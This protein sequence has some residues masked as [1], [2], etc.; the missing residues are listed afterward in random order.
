MK[1]KYDYKYFKDLDENSP[2][3]VDFEELSVS[4]RARLESLQGEFRAKMSVLKEIRDLN[5]SD[6][7]DEKRTTRDSLL[8][9]VKRVV[10]EIENFPQRK[11]DD[12][13]D[14]DLDDDGFSNQ[15]QRKGAYEVRSS[16]D[17][18]DFRALFG[19]EPLNH[20][21]WTDENIDFFS[22]VFAGR[23]HPDLQV[24]AM[25]IGVDSDGGFLV[26]VEYAEEIHNVSLENEIVMPGAMVIPM[27]VNEKKLPGLNIGDHSANLFGGFEASYK[28][29]AGT[30]G[31]KNPKTRQVKLS[32]KK[33]TGFLRL[34]RELFDDIP[35]GGHQVADICG[36]GLAWYRD[37]AFLKG[38]GAGEPQG[39][40]N[41]ACLVTVDKETGQAAATITYPNLCDMMSRMFAGSFKNSV[42]VAHQTCIPQLLQLTIAVGTGGA[43][44]PV[45]TKSK[46]GQFEILTRPVIF[47]EKT[48]TLGTK[49]DIMLCDFGQYV[50][51]LR[52][53]MRLDFSP[54]VYFATD[55]VAARLIERHDG[56]P[57]WSEALTLEDGSTTV[58]PFVTLAERT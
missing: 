37:K 33:L 55:E 43:F 12:D 48:E 52:E 35:G 40:L 1:K 23:F 14:I 30:L 17:K 26:P 25:S 36:K 9:D 38:T 41:S 21:R 49:G 53:E 51:G 34:S 31:E 5:P 6:L 46:D 27:K 22:A 58:S 54:H 18:K 42:W 45:L 50:V 57:L 29:E 28:P 39:I 32:C 56:M 3:E 16:R 13:F 24:R 20:Y 8:A 19:A 11:R 44:I 10:D 7:T 15:R 2:T 47:T 4:D